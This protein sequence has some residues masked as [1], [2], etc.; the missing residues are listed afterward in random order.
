MSKLLELITRSIMDSL[1][2][3][4][5]REGKGIWSSGIEKQK[6][7]QVNNDGLSIDPSTSS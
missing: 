6:E 2:K 7:E 3:K 5:K 1:E 4:L